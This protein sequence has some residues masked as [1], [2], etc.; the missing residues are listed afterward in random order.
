[1][2]YI[3]RES[4]EERQV[5]FVLPTIAEARN[6]ETLLDVI[7]HHLDLFPDCDL[8][9]IVDEGAELQDELLSMD[10][11]ETV[12]VPDS[13]D[14]ESIAKGR[15]QEYFIREYVED[16]EWYVFIDDDSKVLDR[17]FMSEIP[18]YENE[19]RVAANGILYPRPGDSKL[20]FIIDHMRTFFDKWVLRGAIG[21]MGKPY[22]GLHGEFLLVKGEPLNEIGF[23]YDTIVEDFVFADKLI[24]NDYKTWQS[25]TNTSILSPHTLGGLLKQRRRWFRGRLLYYRRATLGVSIA[26]IFIDI[27]WLIGLLCT[28]V[29]GAIALFLGGR[30]PLIV[31]V[32]TGI[33]ALIFTNVY[34]I[35]VIRLARHLGWWNLGYLL[36][37]PIFA[38][39]EHIAAWYALLTGTDTFEVI[40]K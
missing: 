17:R 4:E 7:E 26:S 28:W 35:G 36:V 33:A 27:I 37:L 9:V 16:D 25:Q 11:F 39:I 18:Y 32:V 21:W 6:R 3:E 29:V 13:F 23:N 5:T 19:G 10:G 24:R 22:F 38:T 31:L 20:S 14:P 30:V 2:L 8:Y 15:A 12:V 1:M 40:D 34:V